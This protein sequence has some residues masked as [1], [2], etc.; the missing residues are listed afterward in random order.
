MGLTIS[1]VTSTSSKGPKPW[2]GLLELRG[3]YLGWLALVLGGLLIGLRFATQP[4]TNAA[5]RLHP[6]SFIHVLFVLGAF[7]GYALAYGWYTPI[8]RGDRFMLS[9]YAPLALSLVWA[10]E[11][12]MRRARR[13]QAGKA[14]IVVYHCT[15]WLLITAIAW[16]LIEILQFPQF[17]A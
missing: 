3:V 8:G 13:R 15:Q 6:E 1:G 14:F 2:K 5:Q 10:C 12:L 4:A 9:L 11:S 17:K 7:T 16:R